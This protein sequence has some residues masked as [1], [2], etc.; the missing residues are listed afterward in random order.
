M[1]APAFWSRPPGLVARLLAPLGWIYGAVTVW[2]MGRPGERV[3][4]PVICI[5]NLTAGGA[6]KTPTVQMLAAAL[7]A[8]GETPFVVSRG[9]GGRLSGPVRVAPDRMTAADCGDE[10]RLLARSTPVIVARDRLA[11]ARLAE[12]EGATL[13]LLDDGLQ[14]PRLAKDCAIAVVDSGSMLGH[15]LGN[16]LCLPAGPLRAPVAVQMRH[17][18][19]VLLI[20][21][22]LAPAF[23][24]ARKPLF[25]ARIVPEPQAVVRLAG[26]PLLAFAGI[27]RPEKFFATLRDSGLTVAQTRAFADHHPFTDAEIA[28]LRAEAAGRT[29][30]TTEKDAA[31]LPAGTVDIEVLP[32]T[33][34]PEGDEL[35]ELV[36]AAI[37]RRRSV[38][39][40]A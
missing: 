18:D 20:G 22:G 24:G 7:R 17:V 35:L 26:R 11:G 28:S 37:A 38:R 14:N 9:Y 6:G 4:I 25:R 3:G 32:I 40:F 29:L 15:G 19:A 31:R 16:G 33:L 34:S 30:V 10:P 23:A 39:P 12:A 27:G 5:G 13:V 2:R 8:R 1:K 36:L 21:D